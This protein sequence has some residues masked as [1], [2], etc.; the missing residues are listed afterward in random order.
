MRSHYGR[1]FA[2]CAVVSKSACA[3]TARLGYDGAVKSKS[4]DRSTAICRRE[5]N[6]MTR[7]LKLC[8]CGSSHP[9]HRSDGESGC[10]L[11]FY[12]DGRDPSGLRGRDQPPPP[13]PLVGGSLTISD[14]AFFRGFLFYLYET[15]LNA[16]TIVEFGNTDFRLRLG[17]FDMPVDPALYGTI[18]QG[19]IGFVVSP[20]GELTGAIFNHTNVDTIRMVINNSLVTDAFGGQITMPPAAASPHAKSMAIGS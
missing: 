3:R 4:K 11:G 2:G 14:A 20:S 1:R 10:V 7:R 12:R 15:D 17:F 13:L 19:S 9:A 6:T 18:F 16:E 5:D 8:P